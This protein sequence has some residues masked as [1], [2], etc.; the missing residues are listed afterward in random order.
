MNLAQFQI[1]LQKIN[2]LDK[3]INMDGKISSIEKDLMKAY[4]KQLYEAC[5]SEETSSMDKAAQHRP[6]AKTPVNQVTPPPAPQP[7]VVEATPTPEV[8][9]TVTPE[10]LASSNVS[11]PA[12]EPTP[13]IE[14]TA[15]VETPQPVAHTQI[16]EEAAPAEQ[17]PS[18]ETKL[19]EINDRV[20]VNIK[21]VADKLSTSK[22]QSINDRLADVNKGQNFN[23]K[24]TAPEKS[25]FSAP[26]LVNIPDS[27]KHLDNSQV[28]Q[29]KPTVTPPPPPAPK[30]VQEAVTPTPTPYVA[31]VSTPA[32]G[33]KNLNN[34]FSLFDT[35]SLE[36]ETGKWGSTPISDLNKSIG[37]NDKISMIKELFNDDHHAF[38]NSLTQLNGLGSFNE[39]KDYMLRNLVTVFNWN[40][41]TKT[42]RA[43]QLIN[44]VRRRYM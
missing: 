42:E 22:S 36:E 37:L 31:E 40:Q 11:I 5:T 18:A 20:A 6:V 14:P 15:P 39:A 33:A 27:I 24:F 30:P 43:K 13:T 28:A 44:L 23:D 25:G 16:V 21:T 1:I 19:Q 4:V 10:P 38:N 2:S 29:S 35:E 17:S 3:N 32:V 7:V 34:A 12:A 9:T 8:M 41:G 26:V